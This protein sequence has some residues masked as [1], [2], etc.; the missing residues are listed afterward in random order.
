MPRSTK[1]QCSTEHV[2]SCLARMRAVVHWTPKT[3]DAARATIA[4]MV[5]ELQF[6]PPAAVTAGCLQWGR[7]KPNWPSLSELIGFIEANDVIHL[8]IGDKD[9][10]ENFLLRCRRVWGNC[11]PV[12]LRERHHL[13]EELFRHHCE[14]KLSDEHLAKCLPSIKRGETPPLEGRRELTDDELLAAWAEND[15][16]GG[17]MEA[18]PEAYL[19]GNV[20]VGVFRRFREKRWRDRPDLAARYYGQAIATAA[21]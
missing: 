17:D 13:I 10:P 1:P 11:N 21:E 2:T 16:L 3:E 5:D 9:A 7:Q 8:A 14:D 20:L 12:W 4:A 6:Y 15:R 18:N 19:L